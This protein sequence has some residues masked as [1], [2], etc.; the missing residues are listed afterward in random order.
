MKELERM[1]EIA[2]AEGGMVFA[3]CAVTIVNN[4]VIVAPISMEK[5]YDHENR[6]IVK[7]E[8]LINFCQK[9][10]AEIN[11]KYDDMLSKSNNAEYQRAM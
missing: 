2:N 5:G 7:G 11:A 9:Y 8:S 6:R 3:D 10:A 4:Q 1:M